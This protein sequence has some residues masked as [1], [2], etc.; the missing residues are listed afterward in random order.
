MNKDLSLVSRLKGHHRSTNE[1]Q[2][3]ESNHPIMVNVCQGQM[4]PAL[5]V[6]AILVLQMVTQL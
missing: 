6:I 2:I 3:G 4:S 1:K 5:P